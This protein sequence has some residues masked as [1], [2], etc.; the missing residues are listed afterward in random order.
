MRTGSRLR[1]GIATADER[2]L[3]HR[4][5]GVGSDRELGYILHAHLFG[6]Q[7]PSTPETVKSASSWVLT[8]TIEGPTP[9]SGSAILGENAQSARFH[10]TGES[11]ASN[12]KLAQVFADHVVIDHLG[13]LQI[14]RLP[15]LQRLADAARAMPI[16]VAGANTGGDDG[17]RREAPHRVTPYNRPPAVQMLEPTPH[18]DAN[19]DFAGVEVSVSDN[20]KRLGFQAGDVITEIDGRP[21]NS[22][23]AALK[24]MREMSSADAPSQVTVLRNGT[25]IG[26]TISLAGG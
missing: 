9:E 15:R 24:L 10:A 5:N 18:I 16:L 13:E 12:F 7:P 2:M 21:V 14:L 22:S 3:A 25:P 1:T 8:G 6:I 17:Q 26:L 20:A 4:S 11:I 23:A 19:G